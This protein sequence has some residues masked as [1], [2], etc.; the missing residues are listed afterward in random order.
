MVHSTRRSTL[1]IALSLDSPPIHPQIIDKSAPRSRCEF[2]EWPPIEG[3]NIFPVCKFS[4]RI[5]PN[6]HSLI[7]PLFF[8]FYA[9]TMR[10]MDLPLVPPHLE[11]RRAE[12]TAGGQSRR[13]PWRPE[14]I[15]H[16]LSRWAFHLGSL[17][18][19]AECWYHSSRK[20]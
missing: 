15:G 3:K 12:P 4:R 9:R 17:E 11:E 7:S 20:N 2:F 16:S 19:E 8:V 14:S 18:S 13:R 10:D 5:L 6:H 1:L